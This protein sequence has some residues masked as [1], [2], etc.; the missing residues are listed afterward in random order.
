MKYGES[1]DQEH[2]SDTP[3]KEEYSFMQETIKDETG[4]G[5]RVW[6]LIMKYIGLG[7]I[8]GAA[9]CCSFYALRP[10]MEEYFHDDL[11]EVTIP[12]EE[13]EEIPEEENE[14]STEAQ[15]PVFTIDNYRE[16][17]RGLQCQ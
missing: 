17:N 4:S 14:E 13:E 12:E 15:T 10:V 6:K 8:F 9:T 11:Q 3:E 5:K 7:F 1:Q 2:D 16:M